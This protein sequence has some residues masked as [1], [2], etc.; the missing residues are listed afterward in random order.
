MKRMGLSEMPLSAALIVDDDDPVLADGDADVPA[1][2]LQ[3]V[4]RP[5]HLLDLDLDLAEIRLGE[6]GGGDQ[7]CEE[8]DDARVTHM[9]RYYPCRN[10]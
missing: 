9:C 1:G 2:P 3:H 6:G 7:K 10:T 8:R 4:D 5:G